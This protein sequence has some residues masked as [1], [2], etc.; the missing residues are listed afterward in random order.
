MLT[1]RAVGWDPGDIARIEEDGGKAIDPPEVRQ[2]RAA[3]WISASLL[4]ALAVWRAGQDADVLVDEMPL[5]RPLWWLGG[6]P[7]R[8]AALRAFP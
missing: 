2:E 1:K 8:G 7:P 3:R 6:C 4:L 5:D